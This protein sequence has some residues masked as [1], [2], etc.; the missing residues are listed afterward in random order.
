MTTFRWVSDDSSDSWFTNRCSSQ[1]SFGKSS[2]ASTP[3][4]AV[5]EVDLMQD[6]IPLRCVP[7]ASVATTRSQHWGGGLY[8]SGCTFQGKGVYLAYW[9]PRKD[10]G[11][12]IPTPW[13]GHGTRHAHSPPPP[14]KGHLTRYTH[15]PAKGTL[16]QA[17]PPR[18]NMAQGIPLP[19]A[20]KDTSENIT[21]GNKCEEG[22]LVAD[23]VGASN[24]PGSATASCTHTLSPTQHVFSSSVP[25]PVSCCA[26]RRI[27]DRQNNPEQ[28]GTPDVITQCRHTYI[29]RRTP[30]L[31]QRYESSKAASKHNLSLSCLQGSLQ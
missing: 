29:T 31:H 4:V 3:R 9:H 23:S 2:A 1:H 17:Y 13:K 24:S 20:Q 28:S 21:S 18:R 25:Y 30:H 11:P 5:A 7:S 10:I 6:S 22:C 19:C 8:L 12:D 26:Y 16:K 27:T 14:Q 15:L